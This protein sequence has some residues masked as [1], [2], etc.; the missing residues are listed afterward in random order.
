M[1]IQVKMGETLIKVLSANAVVA[2]GGEGRRMFA[3]GAIRLNGERV[4]DANRA[5]TDADFVDGFAIVQVGRKKTARLAVV[6]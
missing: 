4:A 1:D 5:L 2:G 3:L 6:V